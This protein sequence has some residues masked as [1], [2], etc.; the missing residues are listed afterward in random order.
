MTQTGSFSLE[1]RR[2]GVLLHVTSL[3]KAPFNGDLGRGAYEFVDWLAGAH[4]GW[5]QMLPISPV[6]DGDSPYSTISSFAGESLLIS[7]EDLVQRGWLT[8][9]EC[10]A[11]KAAQAFSGKADFKKARAYR[12]PLL[13]KAFLKAKDQLPHLGEFKVFQESEKFWLQD[14]ALFVAIAEYCG[15]MDW[16]LW[17]EELRDRDPAALAAAADQLQ[18]TVDF[19]TFTQFIFDQQ[20]RA[21]RQYAAQKGVG[22]L[23]DLPIFVSHRSADVWAHP[24]Y[25]CLDTAGKPTVV[26]GCPPDAF[27]ADGQLW[28]NALYNWTALEKDG[29]GWW[30]ERLRR[31]LSQF[32]TVRLDHFIGFHRYWEIDAKAKTARHGT[33]KPVPGEA[34]FKAAFKALGAHTMIAEDLGAVVPPVRALRDQFGFPGMKIVQFAFDGSDEAVQHKPH[35]ASSRSVIY[36]GTH[37]N[38]TVRGWYQGLEKR[39]QKQKAARLE[40]KNVQAY[41]GAATARHAPGHMI[42]AAF[43]AP[44]HVA[45]AA[46]QDILGLGSSARM[47]IPG[48][49][50]GNWRYR[51]KKEELTRP[52]QEWLGSLTKVYDRST[53]ST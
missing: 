52:L 42:R 22:L 8:R 48:V 21:L 11:P 10:R 49:A 25:F 45:I 4:Q 47:N 53:P 18:E 37:D 33:W 29:F 50:E 38:D 12:L 34:F 6:G 19:V 26:A 15:T 7:L 39:A 40:L 9:A 17:P 3:P 5:W 2:A 35:L 23:G 16:T 1:Q 36:P 51:V 32:D 24:Q 43:A 44:S 13:K 30:I 31:V 41:L 46:M 27:N 28:G 14:F 20:W